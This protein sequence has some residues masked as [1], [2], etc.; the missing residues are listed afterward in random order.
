MHC[1]RQ[2]A[3]RRYPLAPG[4]LCGS[5]GCLASASCGLCEHAAW[6]RQQPNVLVRASAQVDGAN[7][8][9]PAMI[10]GIFE[11][12][13][14]SAGRAQA[15]HADFVATFGIDADAFPLLQFRWGNWTV[16]FAVRTN[17]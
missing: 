7:W 11:G 8:S 5:V 9:L 14:P 13:P 17:A 1:A 12:A 10:E 6:P 3:M 16:P 4:P 15:V 2:R